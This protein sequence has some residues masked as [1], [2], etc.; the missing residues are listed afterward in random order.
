MAAEADDAEWDRRVVRIIVRVQHRDADFA[1]R[2]VWT[3]Q[4]RPLL[5]IQLLDEAVDLVQ[6]KWT[7]HPLLHNSAGRCRFNSAQKIIEQPFPTLRGN[8]HARVIS[9]VFSRVLTKKCLK[10]FLA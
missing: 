8:R 1:A 2:G 7:T 10:Q 4:D 5:R 6:A 9:S 3:N